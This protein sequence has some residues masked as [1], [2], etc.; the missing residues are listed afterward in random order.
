MKRTLR[1]ST[2]SGLTQCSSSPISH[3]PRTNALPNV[4]G[5]ADGR[6]GPLCSA[7]TSSYSRADGPEHGRARSLPLGVMPYLER[8]RATKPPWTMPTEQMLVIRRA[9]VLSARMP[10]RLGDAVLDSAVL[11]G[12][13]VAVP[14]HRARGGGL[15]RFARSRPLDCI[16]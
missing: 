15:R 11:H 4:A 5:E 8:S 14:V 2:A 6:A 12:A 13:L 16:R 9:T 10:L 3:A 1:L 7:W